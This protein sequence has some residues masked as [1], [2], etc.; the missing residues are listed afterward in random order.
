MMEPDPV[1][2]YIKPTGQVLGGHAMLV[3]AV[4]IK[5]KTF[6]IK[7]SWGRNWGYEGD[8][9]ITFKDMEKLLIENG[10]ACFALKRTSKP[11][12]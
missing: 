11:R 5:Y 6:R 7:N 9:F 3:T 2:Y 12:V 4:N 10:E 1:G 8:C